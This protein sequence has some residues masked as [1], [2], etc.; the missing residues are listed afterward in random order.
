LPAA[1]ALKSTWPDCEV[2]WV[3]DK[4]FRGIVECCSAVDRVVVWPKKLKEMRVTWKELGSFDAAIDLQGLA[5]SAAV[6]LGVKATKK[7]GYHWQREGAWLVSQRVLPDPS[8]FHVV[9]QYVDVVRALGASCDCAEFNLAPKNEDLEAV[10]AVLWSNEDALGRPLVLCNAGAGWASKR[11]PAAH[12]AG[13]ARELGRQGCTVGFLGA[14]SDR[15][16]FD[17]V[18]AAEPGPVLDLIGKT[19]VRQLVALISH[20]AVHV[21]GDTGSSHIAAALG[22][23]AV[24]LYSITRPQR[25]CPYGQV[26]NCFYEPEGLAL[27]APEGVSSR[28]LGIVHGF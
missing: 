8:S 20:A 12:F 22:I 28:V 24:G 19:N 7:V 6:I 9:D 27:I 13:L 23:P 15:H 4:R 5:K 25:S 16:A 1:A 14:E 2:V 26:D 10:R 21:G 18:L 17:E 11:W 3:V